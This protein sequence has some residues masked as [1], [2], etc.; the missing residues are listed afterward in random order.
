[1]AWRWLWQHH[2]CD[3]RILCWWCKVMLNLLC[4]TSRG[5]GWGFF[6][7]SK[8]LV[9]EKD[10]PRAFNGIFTLLKA[11]KFLASAWWKHLPWL[12]EHPQFCQPKHFTTCQTMKE[13]CCQEK[14][15]PCWEQRL[16]TAL[17]SA[18]WHSSL[19]VGKSSSKRSRSHT[20]CNSYAWDFY[21]CLHQ[22]LSLRMVF[23]KLASGTVTLTAR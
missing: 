3:T 18:V 19:R 10:S 11:S 16:L 23:L 4:R 14:I 1:M 8:P 2:S 6:Q 15:L 22:L 5:S 17:I 13:N 7:I 21:W 12:Q 9:W 20:L